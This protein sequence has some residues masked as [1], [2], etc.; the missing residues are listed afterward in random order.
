MNKLLLNASAILALAACTPG[1]NLDGAVLQGFEVEGACMPPTKGPYIELYAFDDAIFLLSAQLH[2]EPQQDAWGEP[3]QVGGVSVALVRG[4]EVGPVEVVAE[5]VTDAQGRVHFT[6]GVGQLDDTGFGISIDGQEPVQFPA[7][8]VV[9][10]TGLG[11]DMLCAYWADAV[12]NQIQ[13]AQQG[14]VVN[15]VVVGEGGL[16]TPRLAVD[17]VGYG[18]DLSNRVATLDGQPFEDGVSVTP[19]IVSATGDLYDGSRLELRIGA[20]LLLN[21]E[22]DAAYASSTWLYTNDR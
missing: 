17:E 15:L 4:G 11:G 5:T 2:E 22:G 18:F 20:S 8:T 21:D 14:E 12:G 3:I 6:L 19:W 10:R 9:A 1:L 16:E 13:D 7:T